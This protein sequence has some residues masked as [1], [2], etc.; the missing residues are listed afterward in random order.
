MIHYLSF[1]LTT[2]GAELE[3]FT[4]MVELTYKCGVSR[5]LYVIVPD[6]SRENDYFCKGSLDLETRPM[7]KN[8]AIYAQR[9]AL[10]I[11]NSNPYLHASSISPK[12]D[13]SA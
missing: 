1:D 10:P 2:S 4:Q 7:A 8:S 3:K 12:D 13:D 9:S 11:W 6:K 5:T